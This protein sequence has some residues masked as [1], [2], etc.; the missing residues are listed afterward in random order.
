VRS[1]NRTENAA[2]CTCQLLLHGRAAARLAV[3]IDAGQRCRQVIAAVDCD[4][5][6]GKPQ[7]NARCIGVTLAGLSIET[8][9]PQ[10]WQSQKHDIMATLFEHVYTTYL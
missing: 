4:A 6:A 9:Q 5:R 3:C 7:Q 2:I 10:S 8:G 1:H